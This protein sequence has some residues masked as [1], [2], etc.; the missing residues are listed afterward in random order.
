MCSESAILVKQVR[1][2]RHVTVSYKYPL[3]PSQPELEYTG[4]QPAV[5]LWQRAKAMRFDIITALV[6]QE[7]RTTWECEWFNK[8]THD[9]GVRGKKTCASLRPGAA[10]LSLLRS[11]TSSENPHEIN[12]SGIL[13]NL[14]HFL[15]LH[16]FWTPK[17]PVHWE[18]GGIGWPC[19]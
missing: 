4:R 17:V 2:C 10:S 1:V 8:I 19:G 6:N 15:F 5:C 11:A 13:Y 16:Y 7:M 18:D 9:S 3:R 12:W 14:K